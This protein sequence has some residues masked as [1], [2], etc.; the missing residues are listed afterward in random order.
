[1]EKTNPDPYELLVISLPKK[2]TRKYFFCLKNTFELQDL[3]IL[4]K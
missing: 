4:M 1:M 3:F 2:Q